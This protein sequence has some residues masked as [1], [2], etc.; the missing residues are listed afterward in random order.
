MP[1]IHKSLSDQ[2]K[3]AKENTTEVKKTH[4]PLGG[5]CSVVETVSVA[6]GIFLFCNEVVGKKHATRV[7]LLFKKRENISIF[8]NGFLY[9]YQL[10]HTVSCKFAL[11]NVPWKQVTQ[12]ID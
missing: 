2:I 3:S 1:V 8:V 10:N 4:I 7:L 12:Y 5:K 6:K 9:S 11:N